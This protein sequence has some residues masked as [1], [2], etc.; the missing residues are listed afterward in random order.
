MHIQE[1]NLVQLAAAKDGEQRQVQELSQKIEQ[2]IE[3]TDMELE[4]ELENEDINLMLRALEVIY[5]SL[6][7]PVLEP[8]TCEQG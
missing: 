2:L 6:P 5:Q 1:D 4:Q 3:L 8:V 7:P